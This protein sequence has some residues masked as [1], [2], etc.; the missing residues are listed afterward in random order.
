MA[1]KVDAST[2]QLN[3]PTDQGIELRVTGQ[4]SLEDIELDN[5]ESDYE[6]TRASKETEGFEDQTGY[7]EVPFCKCLSYE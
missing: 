6:G 4:M 3:T 5:N 2:V 7:Y 1:A